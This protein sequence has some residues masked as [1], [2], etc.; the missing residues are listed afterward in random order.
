MTDLAA[1]ELRSGNGASHELSHAHQK[2]ARCHAGRWMSEIAMAFLQYIFV[3]EPRWL[4][5]LA[6]LDASDGAGLLQLIEFTE[7]NEL[8]KA[9]AI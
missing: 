6:V 5:V 8:K 1:A 2:R 4:A 3:A 9:C 7:L